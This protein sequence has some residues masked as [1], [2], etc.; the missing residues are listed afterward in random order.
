[1]EQGGDASERKRSTA[2]HFGAHAD[3]YLDSDVHRSGTDLDQLASWCA[4]SRR[5][6][7]VATGAGHTAGALVEA[8]VDR[9][10]A[11]D[12]A[13]DMVRTATTAFPAVEGVVCDAEALPFGADAF[14]A[15]ACRIAAHH[16]PDPVAF[17]EA[18]ARVLEPGG[19]FAFEDNVAPADDALD[20]FLNTVERLRDPTH[21]RSHRVDDWVEWLEGAGFTVETARVVDKTLAYDEWVANVETP[22]AR[23]ERLEAAF[24]DPPAGA[25]EAFDVQTADGD[26]ES[27]ANQ[28]VLLRATR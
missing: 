4:S 14:D 9:V 18:V 25:V 2:A 8:G 10:V 17:V 13:P 3:A 6:L 20:D 28:K 22:P 15:V 19:T 11:T 16:F 26:V 1:M 5:A 27:F 21:V 7:D 24:A 23:R 12:A